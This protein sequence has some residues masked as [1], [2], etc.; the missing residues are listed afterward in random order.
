[1]SEDLFVDGRY[2]AL[3]LP[4]GSAYSRPMGERDRAGI[5]QTWAT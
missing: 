1:M 2:T 3:N 4:L 5:A